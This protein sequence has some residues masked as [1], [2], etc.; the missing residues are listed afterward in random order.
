MDKIGMCFRTMGGLIM[1]KFFCMLLAVA[2][3]VCSV[4][5]VSAVAPAATEVT[6]ESS[7][8]AVEPRAVS[9]SEEFEIPVGTSWSMSFTTDKWFAEDHNAFKVVIDDISAGTYKYI[10]NGS[11]EYSY[12]SNEVSGDHTFTT[13]NAKGGVTYTIYIVNTCASELSGTVKVSSYYND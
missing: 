6:V 10:I 5:S 2:L 11:D 8:A 7:G 4:I 3:C 12:T 1:K 9:L 13:T